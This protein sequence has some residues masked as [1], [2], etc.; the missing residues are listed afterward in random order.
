M[1]QCESFPLEFSNFS[2]KKNRVDFLP[3]QQRHCRQ[4]FGNIYNKKKRKKKDFSVC[5]VWTIENGNVR[6]T[7]KL[8][9]D[10]N[11]VCLP[12]IYV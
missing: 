4:T 7:L 2:T 8:F 12:L 11:K 9:T 6:K 1:P 5:T 3:K 10:N